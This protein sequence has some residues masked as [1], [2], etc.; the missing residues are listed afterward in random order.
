LVIALGLSGLL[1]GFCGGAMRLTRFR[2]GKTWLM[3][4]LWLL[5]FGCGKKPITTVGAVAA[6]GPL[7]PQVI[8]CIQTLPADAPDADVARCYVNTVD[9]LIGENQQLRKQFTP[10]AK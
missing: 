10:C 9:Q 7:P 1:E 2:T 8:L 5:A 6:C 3:A 4:T